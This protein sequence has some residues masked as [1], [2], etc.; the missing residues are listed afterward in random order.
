MCDDK[1]IVA[2]YSWL[3]LI[4]SVFIN[5]PVSSCYQ[6]ASQLLIADF[7]TVNTCHADY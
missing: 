1:N 6:M 4:D 3:S 2:T 7:S 5:H